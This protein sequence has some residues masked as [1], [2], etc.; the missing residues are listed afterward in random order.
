[1]VVVRGNSRV[2]DGIFWTATDIMPSAK[3]PV[4]MPDQILC[5]RATV[6]RM[7][8][9]QA[10]WLAQREMALSRGEQ[11]LPQPHEEE[12][13]R[14]SE[15]QCSLRGGEDT[16]NHTESPNVPAQLAIGTALQKHTT[17]NVQ[18]AATMS[19]AR[20]QKPSENRDGASEA[21]M[22][23]HA[24][25]LLCMERDYHG[26]AEESSRRSCSVAERDRIWA[27]LKAAQ[28]AGVHPP[29]QPC[30]SED[31]HGVCDSDG[32]LEEMQDFL[33]A[34]EFQMREFDIL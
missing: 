19:H 23:F 4:S 33:T 27:R 5:K 11:H 2:L 15:S 10:R 22:H 25:N 6:E 8:A 1:M 7:R 18:T 26:P 14:C 20:T 17:D 34:M 29:F 31:P 12:A 32:E 3:T 28:E 16:V 13:G 9:Q 21:F 30:E 24:P